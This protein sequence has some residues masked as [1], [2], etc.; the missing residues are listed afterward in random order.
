MGDGE[1]ESSNGDQPLSPAARLFHAPRINCYIV[2]IMGCKTRI[3]PDVVK[4]GLERTLLKHPRFS[5]KLVI[6]K[7]SISY[8]PF[9]LSWGSFSFTSLPNDHAAHA[10]Y[11]FLHYLS[12]IYLFIYFCVYSKLTMI[13]LHIIKLFLLTVFYSIPSIHPWVLW[14]PPVLVMR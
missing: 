13:H 6:R 11:F 2:A 1:A 10:P 5:S 3:N 12:N 14:V 7:A 8:I 4:A 9:L